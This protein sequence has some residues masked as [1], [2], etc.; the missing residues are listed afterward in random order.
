PTPPRSTH[1]PYTTLFRSDNAT[2]KFVSHSAR[3][4]APIAK[5]RMRSGKISES[6]NQVTGDTAPCWNARK[7]T[8]RVKI[9]KAR[10]VPS[11]NTNEDRKSTRLNSSHVKISY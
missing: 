10:A 9:T 3:T 6:I 8:I 1:I 7:T 11:G 2:R 5:P 4:A